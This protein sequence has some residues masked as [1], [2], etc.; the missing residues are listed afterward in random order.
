[1]PFNYC[2]LNSWNGHRLFL[3][4]RLEGVILLQKSQEPRL[5]LNG[6]GFGKAFL[7]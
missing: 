2:V 1:M 6:C 3:R 7:A 4:I 5:V